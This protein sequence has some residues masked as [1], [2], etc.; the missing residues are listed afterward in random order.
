[1]LNAFEIQ[2][3]PQPER[4]TVLLNLDGKRARMEVISSS[5]IN[6]LRM[7]ELSSFRCPDKL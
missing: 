5:A 1:M 6:P 4:F 2:A 7:R 3:S